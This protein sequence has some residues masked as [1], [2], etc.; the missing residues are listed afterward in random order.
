[1]KHWIP[2]SAVWMELL[3]M[4]HYFNRSAGRDGCDCNAGVISPTTEADVS[5]VI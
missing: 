2:A 4:P 1:M 3:P 5:C